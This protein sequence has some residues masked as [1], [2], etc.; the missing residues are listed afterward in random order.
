MKYWR[1]K[2]HTILE[3]AMVVVIFSLFLIF[4]YTTFEVGLKTWQI[5]S[6]KSELQQSAEVAMKRIVRDLSMTTLATLVIGPSGD[7]IAFENPVDYSTGQFSYDDQKRGLPK[8]QGHII[9]FT[10]PSQKNGLILYRRYVSRPSGGANINPLYLSPLI[11]GGTYLIVDDN[12]KALARN[13]E[14]INFKREGAA[15]TITINYSENIR[16]NA[17][18]NFS[19]QG[20]P[21]VNKGTEKFELKSSIMPK[22]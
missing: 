16:T 4:I 20:D 9:Y 6:I 18:V 22:N 21:S 5:G 15:I 3:L 11:I 8:W 12:A 19:D 13:L 2:G 1:Q 7:Y 14:K 17:R 10:K